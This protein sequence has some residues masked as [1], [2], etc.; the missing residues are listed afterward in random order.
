ML[1]KFKVEGM[2]CSACSSA[3]ERVVGRI[4]GVKKAEVNLMAKLLRCEFDETLVT[5]D[6]IITAVSKAGFLATAISKQKKRAD[7]NTQ[8]GA[9]N[10]PSVKFRLIFSICFLIPLL[11]V[12]MGSMIGL[13][14]PKIFSKQDYPLNYALLQM[15]LATPV[16][17]VN[18]KFFYSGVR[19][20]LH[21]APNMDTLVMTGSAVAYLF[22]VFCIFMIST[23]LTN[24][25]TEIVTRYV[26][27]L[28]FESSAMILTLITVGK[29]LEEKA[30]NKT[31]SAIEGLKN[32]APDTVTLMKDGK[33]V[34]VKASS[35]SIGDVIAVKNGESIAV[36]GV[37][38]EGGCYV[39]E[40]SLTGESIPVYKTV[41]ESV[42]SASINTDGYILVKATAVGEDTTLSKIIELVKDAGSTKAPVAALADKISGIF[43]PTVI[44]IAIITLI[45]WLA[46]GSGIETAIIH[47]VSVLVISCPCA[48]GLATPV[49]VTASVG[50]SAKRGVLIKTATA[51]ELLA[52]TDLVIFDKTGT[53]TNGK[54]K[55]NGL[56]P[57]GIT[58][59][60][61]LQI[62]I[63]MEEKNSHPLAKAVVEYAKDVRSLD[64]E[65]YVSITGKGVKCNINGKHY[66][67]GN[68]NFIK[69]QGVTPSP[70]QLDL[71]NGLY[72]SGNTL[73]WFCLENA[74]IGIISVADSVKDETTEAVA[75][76][77]AMGVDVAMLSGD[78][79][80]VCNAVGERLGIN[81][82]YSEVLPDG[83]EKVVTSSKAGGLNVVFVGDGIND[84][85][86]LTTATVGI[87]V[88]FGTAIAIDSADV[89]LMNDDLKKV[90]YS[91]KKGKKTLRI[92]KQ[93]L[94]WAFIYNLLLIPIAAGVFSF[95]GFNI[96]PML[97]ALA[98]SLSSLFVV[99]NALRLLK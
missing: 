89:V 74:V 63:T 96:S 55:V 77:K 83:K 51:L 78:N 82:V 61:L 95:I 11:Y 91:I 7:T 10:L 80:K 66:F 5:E 44:G 52:K 2:S 99:T 76:I 72:E 62:A 25:N 70:E 31:G 43:V 21:L 23:G 46:I 15:L 64:S 54:P 35:L 85:P 79:A 4:N 40:S 90:A 1:K 81:H 69:E 73:L 58:E 12:S 33:A 50:A 56:Y 98:M 26:N 17:Y 93:N 94:F 32:L 38:I 57:F 29:G 48:L 39:D 49:A 28:Y 13:P 14:L 41:G 27:S 42:K 65:N 37:I 68:L 30:K 84:S 34:V 16:L 19:A 67:T 20:A 92:I 75:E 97:G 24:G 8:G 45:V 3:V 88:A 36:D 18:R 9:D 53:L 47:A 87:A 60:E 6:M 22:G 86:A 59:K 71:A